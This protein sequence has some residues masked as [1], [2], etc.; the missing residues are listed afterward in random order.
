MD[1]QG[2]EFN[3]ERNFSE[4]ENQTYQEYIYVNNNYLKISLN[5]V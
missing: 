4:D 5:Y 1:E 2:E 3:P